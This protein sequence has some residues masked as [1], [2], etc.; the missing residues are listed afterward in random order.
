MASDKRL[1]H[2][3]LWGWWELLTWLVHSERF[4]VIIKRMLGETQQWERNSALDLQNPNSPQSNSQS[5][6]EDL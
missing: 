4:S 5:V 6:L 1:S 3:G 2:P